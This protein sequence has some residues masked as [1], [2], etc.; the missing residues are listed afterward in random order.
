MATVPRWM[1]GQ[2]LTSVVITPQ[3]STTAGV[4]SD[5]ST[6]AV[7]IQAS[8]E[9]LGFTY[10]PQVEEINALNTTRENEV[11]LADG[12]TVDFGAIK[13]NNGSDPAPLR[14]I[15]LAY[16][17][18]KAVWIEGGSLPKTI[19]VY[20]HRGPY[21]DG[22]RGRGANIANLQLGPIDIGSAQVVV[23]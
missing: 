21:S 7:T 23:S 2:N 3:A 8:I 10:T 16:D 6:A 13:V 22:F 19:T 11:I 1:L 4:L 18:F 9:S 5:V 12:A 14:S 17:L 20:G 15:A